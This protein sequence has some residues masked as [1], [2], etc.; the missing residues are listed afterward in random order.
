MLEILTTH[1]ILW[2][3]EASASEAVP[4]RP[5]TEISHG[6]VIIQKDLS[7][8]QQTS[9]SLGTM[10]ITIFWINHSRLPP[11]ILL[12]HVT[13][14][15]FKA[16]MVSPDLSLDFICCFKGGRALSTLNVSCGGAVLWSCQ[17]SSSPSD[18]ALRA[19]RDIGG[20]SVN[21]GNFISDSINR[22]LS[23]S[24]AIAK[25][26]VLKISLSYNPST[27]SQEAKTD[28]LSEVPAARTRKVDEVV[29]E[30]L[31]QVVCV[32]AY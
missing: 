15:C 8:F 18:A 30:Y 5:A 32:S 9:G 10:T 2:M 25:V 6:C 21:N 24:T 14:C 16:G 11:E 19:W 22:A 27:F 31:V 26:H 28:Y 20:V 1:S 13:Q 23:G 7:V 17:L 4:H 29:G 12:V 3:H